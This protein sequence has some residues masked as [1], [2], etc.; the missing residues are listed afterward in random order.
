MA[1][2]TSFLDILRRA[3]KADG[4]SLYRLAKD[5][6]V[7]V[8]VLQRLMAHER[9]VN[10]TTAERICRQVGLELRTVMSRKRG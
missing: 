8:A 9:G 3:I 10:L 6:G 1:K 5:S 4:R 2:R 7:D